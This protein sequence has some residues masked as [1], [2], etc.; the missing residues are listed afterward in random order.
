MGGRGEI[1]WERE[2][3]VNWKDWD[4]KKDREKKRDRDSALDMSPIMK[5]LNL[6]YIADRGN[7]CLAGNMCLFYQS[8]EYW[9]LKSQ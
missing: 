5:P 2:G 1:N 7:T 9:S 3:R 8:P 4:R 6:D